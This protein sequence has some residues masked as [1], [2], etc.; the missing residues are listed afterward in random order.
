MILSCNH[1]IHSIDKCIIII[2]IQSEFFIA[3]SGEV[4]PSVAAL[5]SISVLVNDGRDISPYEKELGSVLCAWIKTLRS[6]PRTAKAAELLVRIVSL[7][8][9]VF[10][11]NSALLPPAIR[12]QLIQSICGILGPDASIDVIQAC[13]IFTDIVVR[14]ERMP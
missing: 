9:S 4:V 12:R 11:Y 10:K 3:L 14:I 7:V 1:W 6:E 13:L 8:A 5:T 2:I